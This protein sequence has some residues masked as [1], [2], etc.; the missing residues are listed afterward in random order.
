MFDATNDNYYLSFEYRKASF[1]EY[2]LI[3]NTLIKEGL[4]TIAD[5]TSKKL[6]LKYTP[7]PL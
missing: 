5:K 4:L 6:L 3:I 1:K 7:K 2:R